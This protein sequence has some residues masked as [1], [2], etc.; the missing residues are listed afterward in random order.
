[1]PRANPNSSRASA[2]RHL[3]RH[4]NDPAEL[5]RNPLV[6]H[7]FC[8]DG[9]NKIGT[10]NSALHSIRSL[11]DDAVR[12][13]CAAEDFHDRSV[14]ERHACIFYRSLKDTSMK[15]L[16]GQLGLSPRQC[17]RERAAIHQYIAAFIQRPS[18]RTATIDYVISPFEFQMERAAFRTEIGEYV[19]AMADYGSLI[20][21]GAFEQ[22]VRALISAIELQ[23]ELGN[24]GKAKA[25]LRHLF[26]LV[27]DNADRTPGTF[28]KAT[29][30][31]LAFLTARTLWASGSFGEGMAGL[32]AVHEGL[33]LIEQADFRCF[34]WLCYDV[35]LERATREFDLGNFEVTGSCLDEARAF[36]PPPD[37][38]CSRN[39]SLALNKALLSF[40]TMR[41]GRDLSSG[42]QIALASDARSLAS[43]CGS[44]KWQLLA[45]LFLTGLQRF[46]PDLDHRIDSIRAN[47]A[48]LQNP[49]LYAMISLQLAD[50]LL[51]TPSWPRTGMFLKVP[52]PKSNF[53]AGSVNMLRAVYL[54]RCGHAA[55]AKEHA[56]TA[57][58]MAQKAKAHRLEASTLRLLGT[59][60]YALGRA[61]EASDYVLAALP[62]AVRYASASACL[63][64]YRSA[65]LITG[66]RRYAKEARLLE[67]AIGE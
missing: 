41:P 8:K 48:R 17:Y 54:L 7:L 27:N 57:H 30:I 50:L 23:L 32:A 63:K 42:E 61:T 52:M 14:A 44:L 36:G 47:A 34:K 40:V 21:A 43:R 6:R 12:H 28:R 11:V 22:K 31:Y 45:E 66:E 20:A 60:A 33:Q 67:R 49:R 4:I 51:E 53:Y 62:L 2:V 24:V 55:A 26:D 3:F 39:A 18:Q 13:Y 16:S 56:A 35:V 9:V 59:A 46:S 19:A 37:A 38:L 65:A 58:V 15:Q 25:F 64:V 29:E 1:M 5:K 10:D